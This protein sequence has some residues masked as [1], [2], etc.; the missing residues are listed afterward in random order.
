MNIKRG[1]TNIVNKFVRFIGEPIIRTTGLNKYLMAFLGN[2]SVVWS[3]YIPQTQN[4]LLLIENFNNFAEVSAPI[5]KYADGSNQ[6]TIDTYIKS[7]TELKLVTENDPIK[8]QIDKFWSEQSALMLIQYH[9]LA[10]VYINFFEF[11]DYV[12]N[13][14]IKELKLL[15][16]QYTY[17]VPEYIKGIDYRLQR[18][19]SYIVSIDSN[20]INLE[21]EAE[22]ILH[23]KIQ[24]P[25]ADYNNYLYGISKLVS[26]GKNIDCLEAGYGAKNTLYRN[27]PRGILTGKQYPNEYAGLNAQTD[28]D[29]QQIDKRFNERYGLQDNQHQWMV[30]TRPM[31]V[32]LISHNANELQLNENNR[33]DFEK[34]CGVLSINP[35]AVCSTY[36]NTFDNVQAAIT[37]F[38]TGSFKAVIEYLIDRIQR[39][40]N[41]WYPNYVF[42]PNFSR[43]A[44]IVASNKKA[45]EEKLLQTKMGLYTRNEYFTFIGERTIPEPEFDEYR[46]YSNRYD[47]W[48][49]K[50]YVPE[51][52]N[53]NGQ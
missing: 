16:S 36:G 3:K 23:I 30:A 26:N 9:L 44:E 14:N 41:E 11:K 15:P 24:N 10:N 49:P 45:N 39:K 19:K 18:A 42:K 17:I 47:L 6:V 40:I 48:L 50:D 46:T 38:Y 35:L 22:N 51:K 29:A 2:S 20:H 1:I 7:G 34:I 8:K 25:K 27:G 12:N 33:T 37:N 52:I 4:N 53:T 21:I 43:I 28:E 5:L 32:T 13:I 31:D